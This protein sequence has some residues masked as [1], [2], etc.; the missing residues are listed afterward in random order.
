L[1]QSVDAWK[2]GPAGTHLEKRVIRWMND[3]IGF[4]AEAFGVFTSGG[5]IANAIALKMARDRAAGLGIRRTGVAGAPPGRR[6]RV[7][8]SD[9]AHFSIARAL[10]LLGLGER[11]LVRVPSGRDMTMAPQAR[12]RSWRRPARPTPGTSTLCRASRAWRGPTAPSCTS[13]PPTAERCCS[14]SATATGWRGS[15]APTA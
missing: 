9:Q 11:A 1:N 10:D 5:G 3:L 2:A 7:Y 13:T 6:L 8:A 14:P 4:G 15:G 12:W